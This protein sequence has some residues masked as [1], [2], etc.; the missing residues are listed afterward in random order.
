MQPMPRA[1]G[2][3]AFSHLPVRDNP[4]ASTGPFREAS[5]RGGIVPIPPRSASSTSPALSKPED[6]DDSPPPGTEADTDHDD[7]PETDTG[8]HEPEDSRPWYM[9][10]ISAKDL[11]APHPGEDAPGSSMNRPSPKSWGNPAQDSSTEQA[12]AQGNGPSLPYG[13]LFERLLTPGFQIA[14][15]GQPQDLTGKAELHDLADRTQGGPTSPSPFQPL[16]AAGQPPG[17]T[18]I[19]LIQPDASGKKDPLAPPPPK[20]DTPKPDTG[21]KSGTKTPPPQQKP[22]P[23][24][25]PPAQ[26]SPPSPSTTGPQNGRSN[27]TVD[28]DK[29]TPF[30]ATVRSA[31]ERELKDSPSSAALLN[32]VKGLPNKI[33]IVPKIAGQANTTLQADGTIVISVNTRDMTGATMSHELAHAIQ[34]A[35]YYNTLK[36][37]AKKGEDPKKKE[38]IDKAVQ[39]GRDALHQVLPL[40]NKS[41][42]GQEFKENE[43]MRGGHVVNAEHTAAEIGARIGDNSTLSPD[44]IAEMFWM[45]QKKKEDSKHMNN[46]L[47]IPKGTKY[48]DYDYG[49]VLKSLGHGVTREHLDNARKKVIPNGW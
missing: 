25:A 38:T 16:A 33:K 46:G 24:P 6:L 39:A 40:Q 43:A 42:Q 8:P 32:A 21:G 15:T 1:G 37:L 26:G 11:P 23:T 3:R 20:K 47:I 41:D 31:M 35:V 9:P 5:P 44:E 4:A 34:Q 2:V 49:P 48:G 14:T 19:P 12:P 18:Q 36:E 30:A 22:N 7:A 13:R 27:M 29:N 17:K 45:E 28:D 10:R